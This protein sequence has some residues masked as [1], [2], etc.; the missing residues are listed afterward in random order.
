MHNNV[1]YSA[2]FSRDKFF[3]DW[4]FT[5][6]CGNNFRGLWIL[7][8]TPSLMRPPPRAIEVQANVHAHSYSYSYNQSF[9]VSCCD[10]VTLDLTTATAKG[11]LRVPGSLVQAN[12]SPIRIPA[13]D[14]LGT[15][16]RDT[17]EP[18]IAPLSC[19]LSSMLNVSVATVSSQINTDT[20]FMCQRKYRVCAPCLR[21]G[22]ISL[23]RDS[24]WA[25]L[26]LR[27]Y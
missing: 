7:L 13:V 14:C 26:V 12:C 24:L 18:S 20:S 6:F 5:K 11:S 8:A 1:P 17:H 16:T 4:P 27:I 3:A 21:G 19:S 10:T 25:L 15:S 23:S 9:V 22:T 2:K